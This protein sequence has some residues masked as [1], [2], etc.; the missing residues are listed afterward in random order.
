MDLATLRAKLRDA[1]MAGT[2]NTPLGTI[3]FVE[4]T[5]DKGETT[6]GELVQQQFYVAQIKMN[7]DGQTG[8]FTFLPEEMISGGAAATP[9]ATPAK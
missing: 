3:S 9:E 1:V 2:Y 5:N 4:T 8:V 6:G 7:A